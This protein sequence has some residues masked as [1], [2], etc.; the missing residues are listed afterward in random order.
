[1][2]RWLII[3]LLTLIA[4]MLMLVLLVLL[5]APRAFIFWLLSLWVR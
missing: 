2:R 5:I 4:L 3:G 1:M